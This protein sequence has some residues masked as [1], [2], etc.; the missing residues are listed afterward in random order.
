MSTPAPTPTSLPVMPAGPTAQQNPALIADAM[1]KLITY[2]GEIILHRANDPTYIAPEQMM[3]NI[4]KAT[5]VIGS[6]SMSLSG[7]MVASKC[8]VQLGEPDGVAPVE[9]VICVYG[10]VWTYMVD[11][12]GYKDISNTL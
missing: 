5:T 1:T 2:I 6:W 8:T 3:Q 7:G 12:S 11:A 10:R 4:R 9:V